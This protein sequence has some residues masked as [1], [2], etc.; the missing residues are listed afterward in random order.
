MRYLGSGGATGGSPPVPDLATM[1]QRMQ[2][3]LEAPPRPH[4]LPGRLAIVEKETDLPVG[5]IILSHLPDA[6][7]A[8]T[9][10]VEIGWHLRPDRWG[11]GYAT[12]AAR[13]ML[14][15]AFEILRLPEVLAV[16]YKENEASLR[17]CERLGMEHLG[18]TDRYYGVTV[19]LFRA[20]AEK[21]PPMN[22]DERG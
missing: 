4:R 13:A 3:W 16:V 20:R 18:E 11:R 14:A 22:A 6:S 5:T 1:R 2:K 12:E 17:V 21:E 10:E 8:A 19:E 15:Y 7:G 9:K